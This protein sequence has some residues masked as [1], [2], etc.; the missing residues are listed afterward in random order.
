[1]SIHAGFEAELEIALHGSCGDGDNGKFVI[2]HQAQ[3]SGSLESI[4]NGH[5][6]IH[7]HGVKGFGSHRLDGL[8]SIAYQDDFHSYQLQ[9]ITDDLTIELDILSH[10]DFESLEPSL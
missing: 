5:L 4:H 10:Q 9:N 7:K 1:M 8:V 2:S 3:L 6:N